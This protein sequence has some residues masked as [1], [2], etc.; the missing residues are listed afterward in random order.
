MRK[1]LIE[2]GNINFGVDEDIRKG[3]KQSDGG[4]REPNISTP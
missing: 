2:R 4:I 1:L 3:C